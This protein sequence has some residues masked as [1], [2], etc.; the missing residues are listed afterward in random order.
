MVRPLEAVSCTQFQ[1]FENEWQSSLLLMLGG[2]SL[3]CGLV[4]CLG[5][6][7]LCNGAGSSKNQGL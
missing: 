2:G 7:C 6:C 4:V 5:R 3:G 1:I